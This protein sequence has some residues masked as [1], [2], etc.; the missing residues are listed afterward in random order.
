MYFTGSSV[1]IFSQKSTVTDGCNKIL[2]VFSYNF[3]YFMR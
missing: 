3:N 1:T 2:S